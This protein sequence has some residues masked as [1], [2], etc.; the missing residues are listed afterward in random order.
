MARRTQEEIKLD[1]KRRAQIHEIR[2]LRIEREIL[3]KDNRE[4][5]RLFIEWIRAAMIAGAIEVDYDRL[6]TV[7]QSALFQKN[8]DE[9]EQHTELNEVA[10][11]ATVE[12]RQDETSDNDVDPLL[13]SK[14]P[15]TDSPSHPESNVTPITTG[16]V[17]L[18]HPR[19]HPRPAASSST[20]V[21][22]AP[23]KAA[24][25]QGIFLGVD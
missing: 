2:R 24:E 11:T 4:N 17:N 9:I 12:G 8:L 13:A 14:P 22:A 6:K 5:E 16:T 15:H 18:P 19:P 10:S 3:L 1:L 25:E 7:I 21:G 23:V 20:Q